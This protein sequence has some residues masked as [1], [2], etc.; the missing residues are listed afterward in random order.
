M[1]VIRLFII[2]KMNIIVGMVIGLFSWLGFKEVDE[3]ILGVDMIVVGG[4]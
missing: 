2:L 4:V 1:M 3:L